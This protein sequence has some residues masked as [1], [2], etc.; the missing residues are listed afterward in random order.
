MSRIVSFYVI[1]LEGPS[2]FSVSLPIF[3]ARQ[4]HIHSNARIRSNPAAVTRLSVKQ[5]LPGR[6]RAQGRQIAQQAAATKETTHPLAE[7]RYTF[8]SARPPKRSITDPACDAV[9]YSH[10][11]SA[12]INLLGETALTR[13]LRNSCYRHPVASSRSI[14][15]PSASTGIPTRSRPM[16]LYAA[17]VP[18]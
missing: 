8:L 14:C 12:P 18:E 6:Q 1:G 4:P 3:P 10:V 2:L 7:T 13:L 15:I 5:A 17:I 11:C 9:P 16:P